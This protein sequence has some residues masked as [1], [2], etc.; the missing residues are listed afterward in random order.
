MLFSRLTD[1]QIANSS[2]VC[3]NSSHKELMIQDLFIMK[4]YSLSMVVIFSVVNIMLAI[5]SSCGNALVFLT[6]VSFSELLISSNIGLA[7]LAAANFFEGVLI[8]CLC[9]QGSF[10]VLEDGCPLP[11]L[12]LKIVQ[13]LTNIFVYSAVLRWYHSFP[14][15]S[16]DI[17]QAKN[18]K[19]YLFN[20]VCESFYQR[21]ISV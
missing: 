13:F 19:F 17:V 2:G 4:S 3:G 7:S 21:P 9:A 14:P 8:H 10:L 5:L 18:G 6:V 15:L 1:F 11:T 20:L 12:E 16:C